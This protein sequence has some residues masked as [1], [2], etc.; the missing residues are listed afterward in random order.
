M[1]HFGFLPAFLLLHVIHLQ[2]SQVAPSQSERISSLESEVEDLKSA[3]SAFEPELV[4]RYG[5]VRQCE[6]PNIPNRVASCSKKLKP[7]AQCSLMC[8]PGYIKT[9]GKTSTR[10]QEGGVWSQRWS[11]RF[12]CSW[13]PEELWTQVTMEILVLK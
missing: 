7:G 10:C 1:I 13:Y 5:L 11:V 4:A 2:T 6:K 8:N 12:L 3:L 9:P